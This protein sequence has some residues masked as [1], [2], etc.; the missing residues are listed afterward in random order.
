VAA[1]AHEVKIELAQE[2]W[3]GVS[4]VLLVS[5][6]RSES[7]SDAIGFCG[8][9]ILDRFGESGFKEAF[10]AELGCFDYGR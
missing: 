1:L 5:A 3:K 9:A 8:R 2:E 10:G 4:V 7:V 6:A